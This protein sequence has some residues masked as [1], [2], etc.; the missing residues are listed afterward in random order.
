MLPPGLQSSYKTY[1]DDTNTIATWLATHAKHCGYSADLLDRVGSISSTKAAQAPVR[2]K[3]KA[4]KAAREAA[5]ETAIS[6]KEPQAKDTSPESPTYTIKVKEF[7]ELAAYIVRT[8]EPFIRV[9]S[10]LVKALR[11][12]IELRKQHASWAGASDD[13]DEGHAYFLGVLEKTWEILKPRCPTEMVEDR[14]T[15]STQDSDEAKEPAEV[16]NLFD[17]LDI[18]EPSQEFLDA[19][20][21]EPPTTQPLP[22]YEVETV[23]TRE[24]EYLAAHCLLQDVRDIRR[25]LCRLWTNYQEGM[26]LAAVAITVNTAI[27]FVR[28]LEDDLVRRFPAKTDYKSIVMIFYAAQCINRGHQPGH[29]QRPDDLF[30][31]AV[32]DL[33]EDL[34]MPTYS[35]LSSLQDV[36]RSGTVPQYKPGHCGLRDK[37]SY[38]SQ[39]SPRAK[40]EDDRLVMLEA[41]PDLVLLSMIT[42]KSP[43]AEDELMRGIRKMG[44]GKDIPLWLVFAAQCFLDAQHELKEAISNGHD[45]LRSSAN[46]IRASIEQN[47]EFHRSLRIVNWPVTNDT[48][49][50]E[51]LRVITEWVG[52]DVVADKWKKVPFRHNRTVHFCT[53]MCMQYRFSVMP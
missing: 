27:S 18:E 20:D 44:P 36:I 9:P 26:D 33:V 22:R 35:V 46:S 8:S 15:K 19:P 51:M 40:I 1:K 43:L 5:K 38:W 50:T 11:C 7:I 10:A 47:L 34:M 28:E 23:Q 2:L 41:F 12:A 31:L 30:N 29:K 3:G 25:F 53:Y 16:R 24:E 32:Y 21:A 13:P 48:Q 37:R 49:F 4:R 17:K 14:L 45:Q 6:A 39:K 52:K 42:S